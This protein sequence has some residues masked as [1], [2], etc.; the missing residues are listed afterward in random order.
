MTDAGEITPAFRTPDQPAVCLQAIGQIASV[1]V[2]GTQR[3]FRRPGFA[4]QEIWLHFAGLSVY[5]QSVHP[6]QID[7]LTQGQQTRC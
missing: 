7:K 2:L 6:S 5:G 1:S 3:Q 4:Q